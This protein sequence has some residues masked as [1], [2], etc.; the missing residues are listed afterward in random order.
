M[1]VFIKCCGHFVVLFIYT[2]GIFGSIKHS[3]QLYPIRA[4]LFS[5]R[6]VN[7]DKRIESSGKIRNPV[8]ESIPQGGLCCVIS[9]GA[10][11][12]SIFS[13]SSLLFFGRGQHSIWHPQMSSFKSM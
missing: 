12:F 11:G 13:A 8:K 6:F 3:L 7:V 4:L 9:Y 2:W 1:L 10:C 5:H